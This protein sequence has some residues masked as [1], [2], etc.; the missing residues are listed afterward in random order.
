MRKGF[1]IILFFAA[2]F[3]SAQVTIGFGA[4][5]HNKSVLAGNLELA[6]Q[7]KTYHVAAGYI[8][9]FSDYS[10]ISN[11][12]FLKA[13]KSF[14]IN[15]KSSIELG[16]GV[17]LHNYSREEVSKVDNRYSYYKQI[18]AGKMLLYLNYEKKVIK[19]GAFTA[20]AFYSGGVAYGG[21]GMKYFFKKKEK[22]KKTE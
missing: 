6:Y 19:D 3:A 4:G 16:T 1:F 12:F 9:P 14:L 13:G 21:I 18:N 22:T 17:A 15:K 2:S 8:V 11:L 10:S 20:Q 7:F 5:I